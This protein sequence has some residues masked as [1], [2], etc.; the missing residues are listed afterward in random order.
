MRM[1]KI[2]LENHFITQE[3]YDTLCGNPGYPRFDRS[4]DGFLRLCYHPAAQEPFGEA[5]IARLLDVDT[6]RI[7][8]MDAVGIDV[9]VMSLMAPGVEQFDPLVGTPSGTQGQRRSR[10]GDPAPPEPLPGLSRLWPSRTRTEAVKEME[11]AV[12]ELGMKGMEDA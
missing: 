6:G 10:R 4:E 11:R 8:A 3:W 9:A 5:L 12:K 1:R 2:D 7:A